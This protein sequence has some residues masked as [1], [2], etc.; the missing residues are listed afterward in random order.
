M[1]TKMY[2]VFPFTEKHS[3]TDEVFHLTEEQNVKTIPAPENSHL[4]HNSKM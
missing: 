1:P 3:D 4:S 2:F